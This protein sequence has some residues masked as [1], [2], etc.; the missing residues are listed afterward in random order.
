M[1]NDSYKHRRFYAVA[2]DDD[3]ATLR[4]GS[5]I[6]GDY[7]GHVRAASQPPVS[8]HPT[9]LAAPE[10]L[11]V[12]GILLAALAFFASQVVSLP[13]TP[14]AVAAPT[15]VVEDSDTGQQQALQYGTE[16]RLAESDFFQKTRAAFVADEATF[17]EADLAAMEL[18]YYEDG[19]QTLSV[20]IVAKGRSGSWWET[21]AGLY[22]VQDR[23]ER[24]YSSFG[25]V[26]LPWSMPFQG[27][28]FIH[29]IPEY[30]DGSPVDASFSGGCI[31][32]QTAD[33]EELFSMVG[34]GTPIL[35]HEPTTESSVFQ[36]EPNIPDM[37]APHYLLADIEN[38]TILASSEL[39]APAPIASITKLMTA[40]V[41]VEHINLDQRVFV[42]EP[43][44]VE[45]IIPR[46]A[47]RQRV[48]MYSLLQLLLMESSNEAAEIIA[49]QMGRDTFVEHMNR[50]AAS[51]GLHDTTFGDASGLSNDNVSTL[52]DLLRLAQY[53]HNNRSFILELTADQY[54]PTAY[55]GDEFG[56]LTNFN[57]L[58]DLENFY[59]GKVGETNAAGQTSL[60]LH[61]FL[62]NGEERI[63]AIAVLGSQNRTLDVLQLEQ[64]FRERFVE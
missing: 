34:V 31:R 21:P 42:T 57:R 40:L 28:F 45:S 17:I 6:P 59:G 60:T 5:A 25:N 26:Y 51:I 27:N 52:N 38:N 49:R 1:Y 12:L 22:E 7:A 2:P 13:Q 35:V 3:V 64:Y 58:A 11:A 55:V 32:L 53:I 30:G 54:V 16:P 18:H 50:K 29:G 36:Y 63:V 23:R 10:S 62:V 43:T 14:A 9:W 47:D 48:S 20:P 24:H 41:A 19:E 8:R 33:A 56:E 61:R 39:N 4:Q 37:D 46:L 44:F 15:V